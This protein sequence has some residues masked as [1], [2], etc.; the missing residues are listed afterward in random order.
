MPFSPADSQI[1]AALFSAPDLAALFSDET[2]VRNL[3]AVE[4]AWAGTQGKLG[5][6]PQ[7]AAGK[8]H[9]ACESL[10][11]DMDLLQRGARQDGVPVSALVKQI[12]AQLAEDAAP[13]VHWGATTQ[14]IMDSA[15]VL[16]IRDGL[17]VVVRGAGTPMEDHKRRRAIRAKLTL[18]PI[19][20]PAALPVHS[21][22]AHGRKLA[23]RRA[24]AR[25][26]R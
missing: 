7:A 22:L 13:F 16:Q 19:P 25:T 11:V 1:F 17:K 14:D 21:A 20:R 15:A 6:I 12:Q 24:Q 23:R 2:F 5:I 4:A 18:G 26:D 9:A 10:R 3:L 8:I